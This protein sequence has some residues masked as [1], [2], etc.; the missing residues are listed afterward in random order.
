MK[1]RNRQ[2]Q[3]GIIEQL[4]KELKKI[5]KPFILRAERWIKRYPLVAIFLSF[6]MSVIISVVANVICALCLA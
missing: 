1:F 5:K 4:E 3:Q 6:T 2:V